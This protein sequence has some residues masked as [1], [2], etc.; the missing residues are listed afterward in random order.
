MQAGGRKACGF[1]FPDPRGSGWADPGEPDGLAGWVH[2]SQGWDGLETAISH[3]P[4]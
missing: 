4:S 2:D 3:P 1:G